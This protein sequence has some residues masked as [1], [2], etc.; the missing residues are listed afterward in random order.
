[1][2]NATRNAGTGAGVVELSKNI[3]ASIL[4]NSRQRRIFADNVIA[5]VRESGSEARVRTRVYACRPRDHEAHATFGAGRVVG[6]QAVAN[7][8]AI[9]ETGVVRGR[10]NAVSKRD[11]VDPEGRVELLQHRAPHARFRRPR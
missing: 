6:A 3:R 8:Q 2:P 4:Y 5:P 10:N 7:F 11:V 9:I 1:M